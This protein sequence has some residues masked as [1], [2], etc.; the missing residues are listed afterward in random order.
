MS[1]R[2]HF[3]KLVK[4]GKEEGLELKRDY[5]SGGFVAEESKREG[6]TPKFQ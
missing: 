1:L 6:L 5:C 4:T 3:E 2:K